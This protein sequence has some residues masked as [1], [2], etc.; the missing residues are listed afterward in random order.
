MNQ[1]SNM[2]VRRT[3]SASLRSPLT[4]RPLGGRIASGAGAICFAF[5]FAA[6]GTTRPVPAGYDG[7][8]FLRSELPALSTE[9]T[10]ITVRFSV[11]NI[12]TEPVAACVGDPWGINVI[13]QSGWDVGPKEIV[14]HPSCIKPFRLRPGERFEWERVGKVGQLQKGSAKIITWAKI[15]DPRAC[16]RTYGCYAF[17][18]STPLQTVLLE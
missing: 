7:R 12:S 11:E 3:H 4:R 2:R 14:D 16:D 5:G 17:L 8:L 10:S 9:V 6:C 13:L 1:P 18:L 15:V